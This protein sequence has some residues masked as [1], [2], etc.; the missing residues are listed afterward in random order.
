MGLDPGHQLRGA[1]RFRH[2]IVGAEP[3]PPDL[4][5]I[6]L[7]GRHH[8]DRNILLLAYFPAYLESVHTGQHQIQ[9][10][11]IELSS[12]RCLQPFITG[13]FDRDFEITQLKIIFLQIGDCF[14]VLHD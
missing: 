10:H 2:I 13:I 3:Q 9:D 12:H 4:V 8:D 6:V 11:Q 14:L 7:F 1:E 5:D